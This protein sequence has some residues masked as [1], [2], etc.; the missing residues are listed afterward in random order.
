MFHGI[1]KWNFDGFPFDE[2]GKHTKII[3]QQ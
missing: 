3:Q 1:I 2:N